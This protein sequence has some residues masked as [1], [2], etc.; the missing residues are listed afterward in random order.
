MAATSRAALDPNLY[1]QGQTRWHAIEYA[2]WAA[3]LL[4]LLVE[5]RMRRARAV[6]EVRSRV[7]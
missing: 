7:A 2:F 4:L 5:G 3:T 1:L 6:D